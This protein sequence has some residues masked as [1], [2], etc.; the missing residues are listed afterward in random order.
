MA[1]ISYIRADGPILGCSNSLL[2]GIAER[3][4]PHAEDREFVLALEE[5][6]Q[7][8]DIN[9]YLF[10]AE[11]RMIFAQAADALADEVEARSD[12]FLEYAARARNIAAE[13]RKTIEKEGYR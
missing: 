2:N 5:S 3:A 10:S 6:K 8:G 4:L 7:L 12:E 1:T 9:L 11:C 13:I